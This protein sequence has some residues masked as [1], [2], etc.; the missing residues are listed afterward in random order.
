M[1]STTN[2]PVSLAP[3]AFDWVGGDIRGLQALAQ[4]GCPS[5]VPAC[6]SLPRWTGGP[7]S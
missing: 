7:V 3:F 2:P 1:A 5:Y 4:S 6:E